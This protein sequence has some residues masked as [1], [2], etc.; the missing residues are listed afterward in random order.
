[1]DAPVAKTGPLTLGFG[2]NLGGQ[3][4]AKGKHAM[5]FGPELSR[6]IQQITYT[7]EEQQ[8]LA[9]NKCNQGYH[10]FGSAKMLARFGEAF[11]RAMIE[12]QRP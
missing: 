2:G 6:K 10:Y 4:A 5:K 9:M 11:A 12:L 8:Y 1:M 7:E 3:L